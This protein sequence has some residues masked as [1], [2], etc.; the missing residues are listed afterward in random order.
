MKQPLLSLHHVSETLHHNDPVR[1]E[2]LPP[3]LHMNQLKTQKPSDLSSHRACKWWTQDSNLI[4]LC[5]VKLGTF[6]IPKLK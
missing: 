6:H 3:F 2:S 4:S 1:E 5:Y